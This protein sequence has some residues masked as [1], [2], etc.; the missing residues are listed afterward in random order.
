MKNNAT[1]ATTNFPTTADGTKLTF[2]P[3]LIIVAPAAN[4][5]AV[6]NPRISP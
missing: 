4:P 2:L 6:I 5:A 3:A 1:I